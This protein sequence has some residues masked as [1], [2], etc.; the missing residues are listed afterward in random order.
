MDETRSG[1]GNINGDPLF[2]DPDGTDGTVGTEDDDL[3]LGAMSPAADAGNNA[4]IDLC[5]LDL[6]GAPRF[7]DDPDVTDTGSGS[8]PIVDMG[9][10]ERGG[11]ATEYALTM[12]VTGSGTTVPAVGTHHFPVCSVVNVTATPG[13][14]WSFTGWTGDVAEPGSA[15]TSVTM[16]GVRS[17][18]A[19]F[20]QPA[21]ADLSITKSNHQEGVTIGSSITYT[22]EVSNAGPDGVTGATVED[23][24][25]AALDT[26]TW[27]CA[28]SGGAS[29]TASPG[30]GFRGPA[31]GRLGDLHR[32]V[33]CGCRRQRH[34][35][36]YG[37][38]IVG[39]NR[40]DS[41]Q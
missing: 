8:A 39:G 41:R 16:M 27:T 6:D 5:D 22:I 31:G 40:S 29:C 33:R 25:P 26:C 3:R 20:F 30:A 34:A 23:T 12:A 1:M 35:R 17:A 32:R 10:Y 4:G 14:G 13:S 15:M 9:A 18:T 24:I 28:A 7:L 2:V 19:N 38:R 11:S 36:E 21:T 37:D